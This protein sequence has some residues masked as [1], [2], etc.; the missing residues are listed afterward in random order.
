MS[1][2][3][4]EIKVKITDS[5]ALQE[6]LRGSAE[7]RGEQHQVDEYFSPAHRNFL[8]AEPVTEWL[9]LRTTDNKQSVNYK[10]WHVDGDGSTNYCDEYETTVEDIAKIRQIFGAL[11]FRPLV[12]VDKT[13]RS[14]LYQNY[15]V[16]LDSVKGL[17]DFVE[18]EYVGDT[19]NLN[20]KH[21]TDEMLQW[22]RGLD[23]GNLERDFRGYPYLL[24]FGHKTKMRAA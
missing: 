5:T 15:E 18:I 21:V 16:S 2:I 6:F 9:R 13:R 4:I 8:D 1:D 24:L 20:P 22:L 7:F 12:T 3:E 17:G 11:D 14:W 23:C 10:N 19:D